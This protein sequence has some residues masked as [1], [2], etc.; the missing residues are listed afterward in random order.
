MDIRS[1]LSLDSAVEAR[2]KRFTGTTMAVLISAIAGKTV[3]EWALCTT[4]ESG[5]LAHDRRVVVQP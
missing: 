3:T 1:D 4:E 5:L 2:G